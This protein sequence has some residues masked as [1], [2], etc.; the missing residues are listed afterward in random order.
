M[1][2]VDDHRCVSGDRDFEICLIGTIFASAGLPGLID[3]HPHLGLDESQTRFIGRRPRPGL[4][5]ERTVY[6]PDEEF[7]YHCYPIVP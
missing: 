5:D 1:I 2:K 3:R 6:D 7:G 4:Y